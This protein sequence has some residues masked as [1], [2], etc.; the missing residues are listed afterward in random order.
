[1]VTHGERW[2][3][4]PAPGPS[5]PAEADDEHAGRVGVEERQL[6][7]VGERV[8]A[9]GDREVDDVDAVQDRLLRRRRRSRS[10]SSPRCRRPCRPMTPGAGR[11]AV[12]RA[13][14]D[15]EDLAPR[16]ATL[17]A[18]VLAVWVPWPLESRA[19]W[20]GS[21]AARPGRTGR[22]RGTAAPPMSLLLQTNGSLAGVSGLSPKLQ[23]RGVPSALAGGAARLPWSANDGCSGQ[24]PVSRLPKMTPAPAFGGRRGPP[25]RGVGVDEVGARVGQR[26]AQRRRTGRRRRHRP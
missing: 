12:D 7:R 26:L 4:V 16:R 10:R 23:A 24:T 15:A 13:A 11:D 5:L 25:R 8:G 1:M 17:P 6:D 9:A 20:Y 2:L 3:A 21:A 18:D 19:V 14:L 22:W